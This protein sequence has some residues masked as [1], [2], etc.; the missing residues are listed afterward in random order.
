MYPAK[1]RLSFLHLGKN[2]LSVLRTQG[3]HIVTA[4]AAVGGADVNNVPSDVQELHVVRVISVA[5]ELNQ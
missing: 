2:A 1:V 3:Q 5:S 4:D